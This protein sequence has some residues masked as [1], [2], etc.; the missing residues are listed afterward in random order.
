LPLL[1]IKISEVNI[2]QKHQNFANKAK[3]TSYEPVSALN[4]ASTIPESAGMCT[5]NV[6]CCL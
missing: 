3:Q 2:I 5:Y 1:Y 6:A 4:A